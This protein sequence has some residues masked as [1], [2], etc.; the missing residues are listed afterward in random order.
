MNLKTNKLMI[1][2]KIKVRVAKID[3]IERR[4]IPQ[5]P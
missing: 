2:K 4:E 1:P 3:L 5:T